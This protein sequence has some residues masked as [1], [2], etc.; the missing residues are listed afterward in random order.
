MSPKKTSLR[1]S[2][3]RGVPPKNKSASDP[4]LCPSKTIPNKK[5]SDTKSADITLPFKFTARHYQAPIMTAVGSSEHQLKRGCLVWHRRAGKE[6]TCFNIMIN[7]ALKRVGL[8][9]YLFPT[10]A[11][12]KK[13]L[14]DGIDKNGMPFLS[15]IPE[16]MIAKKNETEM[17]ITMFNGS[18]IQIVGTDKLDSLMGTNPIGAVLSEYSLQDP[19]GWDL[20][21]PIFSENGGWAIFDFT[22]RGKNHAFRLYR[23]AKY[24]SSWHCELLTVD[25]TGAIT[26]AAIEEERVAGM[27]EEI[28]AQEFYCSFQGFMQG[29]YYSTQ[30]QRAD[31]EGRICKVP[32]DAKLPVMT[33][34]DLGIGDGLSIWFVQAFN[35]ELRVIDYEEDRGLG[36]DK[37]AKIIKEK[38][39]VYAEHYLPH[40]GNVRDLG[41]GKTRVETLEDLG[42]K[43]VVIVTKL[44]VDDGIHAVRSIFPRCWFDEERTSKGLDALGAYKKQWD[45][46]KQEFKQKP[47]HDWSSHGSDAFRTFA[48]GFQETYDMSSEAVPE[49]ENDYNVFAHH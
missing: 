45:E 6:K 15:H 27:A 13:I 11:Q 31:K 35:R 26:Q 19:R 7:E 5:N 49:V 21:R 42:I 16:E 33:F 8:Y 25:D 38:P 12:G 48:V 23:M 39:Y 43:P 1:N 24:N 10:Y 36:L 30:L 46:K 40:D 44:P 29:S 18:I 4:L 28:I 37:W 17:Q 34:W 22:P 9:Y 2:Q 32:H 47:L 41:T 14:W 3:M 20:L